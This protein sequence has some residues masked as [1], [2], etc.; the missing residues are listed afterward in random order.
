MLR[1]FSHQLLLVYI[2]TWCLPHLAV[3][4]SNYHPATKM[5]S[6]TDI[7]A[8]QTERL[9][10]QITDIYLAGMMTIFELQTLI[11]TPSNSTLSNSP[12]SNDKS[13]LFGDTFITLIKTQYTKQFQLEFPQTDHPITAFL[14]T[15]IKTVM[16]ENRA[17]IYDDQISEKG[18]IPAIFAFQL[19]QLFS[20]SRYPVSLKYTGFSD[21]VYNELNRPDVWERK[22]LTIMSAPGWHKDQRFI[23]TM[24]VADK[25]VTRYMSPMILKQA[26]MQCHGSIAQSGVNQNKPKHRWVNQN[27]FG[28]EMQNAKVGELGGGLSLTLGADA[29]LLD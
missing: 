10:R 4:N 8:A 19:S 24:V 26:C 11:N 21:K 25:T 22:A 18:F 17:L 29:F 13:Q 2:I 7:Q 9:A 3:A 27:R 15:S 23:E 5:T 6:V 28:F 1:T 14:M 20:N 16:E 12:L